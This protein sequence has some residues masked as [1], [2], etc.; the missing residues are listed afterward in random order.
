MPHFLDN[1]DA[2]PIL[3]LNNHSYLVQCAEIYEQV[4][5]L[6][7]SSVVWFNYMFMGISCVFQLHVY[8]DNDDFSLITIATG[9]NK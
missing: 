2:H 4:V 8:G 7:M 3:K 6:S 1:G 5:A 9:K